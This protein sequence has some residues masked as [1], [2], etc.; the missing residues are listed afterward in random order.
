MAAEA[1]TAA[2]MVVMAAVGIA[3]GHHS[4]WGRWQELQLQT[5]IT[6]RHLFITHRNM[7]ILHNLKLQLIAQR[8]DSTIHKLKLALAVG[9]E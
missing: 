5:P 3:A 1:T 6:G 7:F 9:K 4:Q 8:T 2:I